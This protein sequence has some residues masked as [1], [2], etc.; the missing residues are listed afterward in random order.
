MQKSE[1]I[2]QIWKMCFHA[3]IGGADTFARALLIADKIIT[4]SPYDNLRKERMLLLIPETERLLKKGN[5]P[6][7]TCI[8]LHKRMENY[9]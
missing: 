5:C 4:S 7:K 1:E 8:K 2:Q 6:C 9:H 3:H